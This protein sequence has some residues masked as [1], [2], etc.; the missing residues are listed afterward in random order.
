M[1]LYGDYGVTDA[2]GFPYVSRCSVVS[3]CLQ[4]VL[5][6][7]AA[8][9]S[10]TPTR[11]NSSIFSSDKDLVCC[12]QHCLAQRPCPRRQL[13]RQHRQVRLRC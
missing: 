7:D 6:L 11:T 10:A 3:L 8:S 2:I 5:V 13:R 4:T 1:R 9:S 12:N